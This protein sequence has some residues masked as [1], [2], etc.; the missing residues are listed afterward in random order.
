M[1]T[2]PPDESLIKRKTFEEFLDRLC[3]Y[4]HN[5]VTTQS[6]QAKKLKRGIERLNVDI[7]TVQEVNKDL[8]S[9][10]SKLLEVNEEHTAAIGTLLEVNKEH[11]SKI[12]TLEALLSE[13][14]NANATLVAEC[15]AVV[16]VAVERIPTGEI[17]RSRTPCSMS[18]H[19]LTSPPVV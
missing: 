16:D 12:Q 17:Y 1:S 6:A 15:K 5:G 13:I 8:S 18:R 19:F 9:T 11:A 3:S 4:V 7:T 10:V 14:K 2:V